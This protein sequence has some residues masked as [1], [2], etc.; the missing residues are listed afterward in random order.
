M[1]TKTIL[2]TADIYKTIKE[3]IVSLQL[4]PDDYIGEIETAKRFSVSRTPIREVFKRLE[5]DKLIRV[6][7]NKGTLITP[8]DFTEISDFMF[9]REKL[10]LGVIEEVMATINPENIARLQ[11]LLF[12]QKKLIQDDKMDRVQQ[13]TAFYQLDNEFH[14]SLFTMANRRSIWNKIENSMPDYQRFR[15]VSAK[16][17]TLDNI[18]EL[19]HHHIAIASC[20]QEN[21][22]QKLAQI[23][24]EH[25]YYGMKLFPTLL[26]EKETYFKL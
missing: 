6:I 15:A 19:Y 23:Y 11:L 14:I 21:D 4:K 13:Y 26:S 2:H 16:M 12:Q 5:L 17:N 9:I 10:E 18:K 20:I 22:F 7:P 24:K 8:I 1:D 25:I 3:E